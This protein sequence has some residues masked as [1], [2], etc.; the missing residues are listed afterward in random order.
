MFVTIWRKIN[1]TQ[2]LKIK[3]TQIEKDNTKAGFDP[4][5]NKAQG[6]VG[7]RMGEKVSGLGVWV[8]GGGGGGVWGGTK[9][10]TKTHGK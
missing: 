5:P 1:L 4:G 9:D 3:H 7:R 6:E 10:Q 2:A 8:G